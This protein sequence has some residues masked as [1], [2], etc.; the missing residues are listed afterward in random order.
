MGKIKQHKV[1][2][3]SAGRQTEPS[4]LDTWGL[5]ESETPTKDNAEAG[6]RSESIYIADV[7]LGLRMGSEQLKY[8]AIPKVVA[9]LWDMF[10]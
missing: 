3:N 9:Y 2:R 5:P 8:I 6:L 10:F 7:Q 4:N 1:D